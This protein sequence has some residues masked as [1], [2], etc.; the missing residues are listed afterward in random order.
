MLSKRV[1][2]LPVAFT[3]V[4]CSSLHASPKTNPAAFGS[5]QGKNSGQP[6]SQE[7]LQANLLRFESQLSAGVRIALFIMPSAHPR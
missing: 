4:G 3:L 5:F 6:V 1:L 7:D 2:V